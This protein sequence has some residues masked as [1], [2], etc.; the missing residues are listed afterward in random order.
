[1]AALRKALC[2]LIL[3]SSGLSACAPAKTPARETSFTGL[4]TYGFEVS[5]F[6]PCD[7]AESERGS[8]FTAPPESGFWDR[9]KR[10]KDHQQDQH[11]YDQIYVHVTGI[12]SSGDPNGYGHLN[13]YPSELTVKKV[14]VIEPAVNG[15]CPA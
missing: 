15:K 6:K 7:A 13:A 10:L 9:Y 4:V 12:M 2:L 1:M 14:F 8:W 5:V 3:L 11:G